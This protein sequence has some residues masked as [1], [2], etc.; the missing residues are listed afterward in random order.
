[1]LLTI[2]SSSLFGYCCPAVSKL[3]S[4]AWGCYCKNMK[5]GVYVVPHEMEKVRRLQWIIQAWNENTTQ[6]ISVLMLP[7]NSVAS[8]KVH[9][10]HAGSWL[11]FNTQRKE[12]RDYP[13]ALRSVQRIQM[14]AVK[15]VEEALIYVTINTLYRCMD[16]PQLTCHSQHRAEFR[17][18]EPEDH[19]SL[20]K[21][22]HWNASAVV[23][24]ERVSQIILPEIL[25]LGWN[26][27]VCILLQHS[28]IDRTLHYCWGPVSS[29]KECVWPAIRD[30][31]SLY[32]R[33]IPNETTGL[34]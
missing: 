12:K 19:L 26:V 28:G 32:G 13:L 4:K 6:L 24:I 25:S 22:T 23:W 17:Y 5:M 15:P 31:S 11:Y 9:N 10:I 16:K 21:M 8:E 20:S 1:M 2:S 3:S 33:L 18:E 29:L 30:I 27:C 34:S 7:L 14:L